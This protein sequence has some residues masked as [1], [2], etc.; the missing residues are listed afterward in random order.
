VY[1]AL[2]YYMQVEHEKQLREEAENAR[3]LS[4][5]T[6]IRPAYMQVEHEKQLREETENARHLSN[7]LLEQERERGR[8]ALA[9]C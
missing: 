3:H 5:T 6:C 1:E 9:V 7:T 8:C 4:N 2:S